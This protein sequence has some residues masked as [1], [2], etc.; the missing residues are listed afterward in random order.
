MPPLAKKPKKDTGT[1]IVYPDLEISGIIIPRANLKV[2]ADKAK[3]LL[4]WENEEEYK[5][6]LIAE[7]PGL[8]KN[9][10][11]SYGDDYLLIDKNGQKIKCFNNL[12][13]RPFTEAH[14]LAMAQ[15]ILKKR[16]KLNLETIII[17]LTG[18]VTSGQHRLIAL[19]LA[20]QMWLKNKDKYKDVWLEEPYIESLIALGGSDDPDVVGT[21]DNVRPRSESDVIY[22]S[23][24][25]KTLASPDRRECARMMAAGI[26]FVWKRT[27]AGETAA[28]TV[29]KTHSES[30]GFIERH[31]KL[32]EAVKHIFTENKGRAISKL[33]MSPGMCS[34]MLYLMAVGRS[35]VDVYRNAEPNP[36]EKVLDFDLWDKAR[37]FWVLLHSGTGFECVRDAII[38]LYDGDEGLGGRQSEKTAVICKAWNIFSEGGVLEPSDLQ[39][40]Y[41]QDEKTK[42]ITLESEESFGGID[43]GE[44]KRETPKVKPPNE[45]EI[46]KSKDEERRKRSEELAATLNARR[47]N[48]APSA[49]ASSKDPT[50]VAKEVLAAKPAG[51]PKPIV[52]KV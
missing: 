2:T 8:K 46:K 3:H 18:R 9:V 29:Y 45:A 49:S 38:K 39:L 20:V 50:E 35:D 27:G 37:E 47:A 34:G 25:F 4:R 15:E 43:L 26:D 10:E 19:I 52:R 14:A 17:S 51:K 16:F 32:L 23:D 24:I 33:K 30:L 44:T 21:I 28:G 13:N 40:A 7:N 1:G 41:S 42:E 22:T 48:K 12:D 31:N 5:A 6:R 11:A 36:N